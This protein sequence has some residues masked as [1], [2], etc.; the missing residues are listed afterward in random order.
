MTRRRR[1]LQNAA[2]LTASSLVLRLLG[3]GFRVILSAYLGG[4]G[5]G[6]YQ[7]I[8]ALYAVF[9][10]LATAGVNVASTRLAAQS[11]ARGQGLGTAARRLCTTALLFG[12]AAMA[13]QSLLAGPL[14]RWLLHDVRAEAAL[15]VLAPSLPFMAVAGALRGC[16]LAARKVTPNV[17]AQLIEQLVRMAV[18]VAGLRTAAQWGVGYGCA[19]VMLGNTV[20]EGVSCGLMVLFA[21]RAPD[22]ARR[23]GEPL[24]PYTRRELYEIVLPVTGSRLLGSGLQAVQWA[25]DGTVEAVVHQSLPVWGVQ[26]HPERLAG[27]LPKSRASDGRR[28]L[29]AWLSLCR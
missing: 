10:A 20:S 4:E 1:Y 26:Y 15:R 22:F 3:M 13:A 12:T 5:M 16:F 18:A 24:Y 27:S 8:M 11:L 28:L 23:K 21:A 7:L 6:L 2:L 29:A 14:A 25:P 19:A 17:T 9:I